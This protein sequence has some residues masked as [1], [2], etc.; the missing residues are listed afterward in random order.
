[1]SIKSKLFEVSALSMGLCLIA[2][3]ANAATSRTGA[4]NARN[5]SGVTSARMPSM[6]T[7]PLISVGNL[8]PDLPSGGGVPSTPDIP[9]TPDTP[10]IPDTPDTPTSCPDGGVENSTYTT[11]MCMDDILRCVNNGGLANGLNDMFNPEQRYAIINGMGLCNVQ[12]NQCIS[13]IRENCK[14]VYRTPTDVWIDFNYRKVQPEYYNF[15]LR[16]TGLTPY[17]AENT[18]MLIDK[19]TYGTSFAAVNA[20]GITTAEYN[21]AITPYNSQQGDI[22]I[23]SKPLGVEVNSNAGTVDAQRG[24]YARWDA[25]TATCYIRVAA[26]NKDTPIS[27]QWLFGAAGDDQNAEIWQPAGETFT[28][29]KD[30]FG[31]SLMNKTKTT[32]VVGIGGGTL[33]GAGIGAIS[34]HSASNFDCDIKE[35]REL[36]TEE[37]RNTQSIS[38]LNQF[39]IKDIKLDQDI[40][41][42]KTCQEI[43]K[44][45]DLVKLYEIELQNADVTYNISIN[46]TTSN[47]TK[48]CYESLSKNTNHEAQTTAGLIKKYCYKDDAFLYRNIEDCIKEINLHPDPNKRVHSLMK[49]TANDSSNI[50]CNT[51]GST[52]CVPTEA[53]EREIEELNQYLFTDSVREILTEV[54]KGNRLKTTLTGAAIG[55]G[56]GG[57]ATAIT[58]FV[59][60]GNINCRVGDG[61]AQVGFGKSHTIDTLKDV[62][63]KWNLNLPDVITPTATVDCDSWASRCATITALEDCINTKFNLINGDSN[64]PKTIENPCVVSGSTCIPNNET[65]RIQCTSTPPAPPTR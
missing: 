8:S 10:D 43:V 34:G 9:D 18:C 39:L 30:L 19:N 51:D 61:L 58:A 22:S 46:C 2:T 36:L 7:L 41:P 26:Y 25:G 64:I 17:Q 38:K 5:A 42:K 48:D 65:W 35:H 37:L 45:F 16:K 57:L 6:P 40:M 27:N 28:C 1:M 14:N 59:E 31:F 15:V 53:S 63:V 24:H 60:K 47:N 33:V 12:V 52:E 23:K 55:A 56:A 29:N 50:F 3:G 32:A 62:Y 54:Q 44:L 49:L 20:S 13:T 21:Q 4:T 11:N